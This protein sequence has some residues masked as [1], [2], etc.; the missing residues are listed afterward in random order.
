[1]LWTVLILDAANRLYPRWEQLMAVVRHSI[2]TRSSGMSHD[3][4]DEKAAN[5]QMSKT[6][7]RS[8]TLG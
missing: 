6:P 2:S 7:A 3:Y 1:M 8:L 4:L 5:S